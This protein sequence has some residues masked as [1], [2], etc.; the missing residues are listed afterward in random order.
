M[1]C[2]LTKITHF[3]FPPRRSSS[4]ACVGMTPV[5][6]WLTA[7]KGGSLWSWGC[8]LGSSCIF[9]AM[10]SK[11]VSAVRQLIGEWESLHAREERL[12][13]RRDQLLQ[14]LEAESA[15]VLRKI[16]SDKDF[17][18]EVEDVR[19]AAERERDK[20]PVFAETTRKLPAARMVGGG[21]LPDRS[22]R[23]RPS[24]YYPGSS[25]PLESWSLTRRPICS[26]SRPH[27]SYCLCSPPPCCPCAHSYY[28][29]TYSAVQ[30][31]VLLF[32]PGFI[33]PKTHIPQESGF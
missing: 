16:S 17:D 15:S 19:L 3:F 30:K 11:E 27:S 5:R 6:N 28:H 14:R 13:R 32:Y 31:V 33:Y 7:T 22:G 4:L 9:H 8:W 1:K 12:R 21:S 26:S 23:S 18:E 24:K 29:A 10:E 20:C 25:G 2:S